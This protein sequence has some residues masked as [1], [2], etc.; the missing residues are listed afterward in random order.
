M[1]NGIIEAYK[2]FS[3][4]TWAVCAYTQEKNSWAWDAFWRLL[5]SSGFEFGEKDL[6]ELQNYCSIDSW[7]PMWHCPGENCYSRAVSDGNLSFARAYEKHAGRRPFIYTGI[8]YPDPRGGYIVHR[9]HLKTKGRLTVGAEFLW[10]RNRVR[11]TSFKDES[12]SLIACAY[13]D[14]EPDAPYAPAKIR[15]RYKITHKELRKAKAAKVIED[16]NEAE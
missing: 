16:V 8:E 5:I 11:V 9:T 6:I 4:Y 12:Q 3:K 1:E 2:L 15:K 13:C 7:H 10:D 14:K